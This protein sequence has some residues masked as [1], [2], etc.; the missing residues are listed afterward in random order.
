MAGNNKELETLFMNATEHSNY[1]A[2]VQNQ[3]CAE[4]IRMLIDVQQSKLE[5]RTI[6]LQQL[7]KLTDS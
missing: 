4:M 5:L 6:F 7:D 1:L 3:K 2:D